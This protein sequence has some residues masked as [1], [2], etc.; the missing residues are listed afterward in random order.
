VRGGL[1]AAFLAGETSPATRD[2]GFLDATACKAARSVGLLDA[3]V[4]LVRDGLAMFVA[5]ERRPMHND[6]W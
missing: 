2:V 1:F 4:R 5:A 3:A 6:F